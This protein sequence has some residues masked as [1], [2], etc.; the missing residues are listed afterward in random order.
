MAIIPDTKNWTWVSER[1][2]PECGF[3]P[4]RIK[5]A[6]V[7]PLL[8]DNARQWA[9]LLAERADV[10]ERPRPD[11]WSPLEYGC[12]VRDVCRIFAERLELMLT[13]DAP[14]FANWDQDETAIADRYAEQ[15]PQTVGPELLS[16]AD[17]LAAGFGRVSGDQ[18]ARTGSRSD[19]SNFTIESFSRYL[20]HD[21]VHHL[22]DVTGTSAAG[23]GQ[24]ADR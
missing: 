23:L 12:H 17:V 8:L 16:A 22:Y 10:R 1:N 13:Q 24:P 3:D 21:P 9:A 2:C 6:Q 18:W 20:L 15:D 19:G 4:Q 14:R 7:G 11:V 5:R